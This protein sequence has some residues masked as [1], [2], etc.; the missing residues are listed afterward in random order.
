MT[1]GLLVDPALLPDWLS[2]LAN[3]VT[4][5]TLPN[6][7]YPRLTPP[8]GQAFRAAAVLILLGQDSA[9]GPDVLLLRR[10]DTLAAHPGQVAFPGGMI[11]TTDDGPVAAAVREAEEE[12]GVRPDGVVP[13]ALL[14]DLP[15]SV[16]RFLVTPVL[17]Y[18]LRP[19]KVAAVDPAETMAVARVPINHLADPAHRFMLRH[20]SGATGPA[21]DAPGMLVWGF[22]AALLSGLLTL[23]GWE[24]P[25]DQADIRE[26]DT[27]GARH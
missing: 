4:D 7:V 24:L 3:A 13:F 27:T 12:A 6:R 9:A 23:A 19:H 11:D 1:P 5:P 15:V 14:P 21:F 2:P 20:P 26:F 16:S 10:A 22:T 17:G 25:W 18:W 8:S